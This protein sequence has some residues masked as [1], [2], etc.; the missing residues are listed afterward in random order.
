MSTADWPQEFLDEFSD[1]LVDLTLTVV[2]QGT[3]TP[4]SY[5]RGSNA[6]TTSH[7]AKGL[8]SR[9]KSSEID[10]TRIQ[11][12]DRRVRVM[13]ASISPATAIK[14]KDRVTIGGETLILMDAAKDP[15]GVAWL[16]QARA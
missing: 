12:G 9:Y 15:A 7:T 1:D 3:P 11:Q 8:V 4:G 13:I 16:C 5:T 6:T 2:A 14:P 10:G